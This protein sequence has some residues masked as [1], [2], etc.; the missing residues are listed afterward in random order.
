MNINI[1]K[2]IKP[3]QRRYHS[4]LTENSMSWK[5][6]KK[7]KKA[8]YSCLK[9]SRKSQFLKK[10]FLFNF[11]EPHR[12]LMKFYYC[13]KASIHIF[14]SFHEWLKL[15]LKWHKIVSKESNLV[16]EF[17]NFIFNQQMRSLQGGVK[18]LQTARVLTEYL[19]SIFSGRLCCEF[20]LTY[21]YTSN[22][23]R[24]KDF[25]L[26]ALCLFDGDKKVWCRYFVIRSDA[27]FLE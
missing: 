21:Q 9:S 27:A 4:I 20:P 6:L 3:S 26:V 7:H 10:F 12:R 15:L 17:F 5:H 25:Q 24:F 11:E 18:A 2:E 19:E 8:L 16:F 14:W 13:I 1:F 23:F 22:A